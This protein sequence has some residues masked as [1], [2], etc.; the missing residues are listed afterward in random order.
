[1]RS[2]RVLAVGLVVGVIA[3]AG[4]LAAAPTAGAQTT[5][6]NGT[7]CTVSGDVDFDMGYG[8]VAAYAQ[9]FR[10]RQ[11]TFSA[12]G[13]TLANWTTGS[14]ASALDCRLTLSTLPEDETQQRNALGNLARYFTYP[15]YEGLSAWFGREPSW[16]Q[17][18]RNKI[19][20]SVAQCDVHPLVVEKLADVTQVQEVTYYFRPV[21]SSA[22]TATAALTCNSYGVWSGTGTEYDGYQN[23][24]GALSSPMK[25]GCIHYFPSGNATTFVSGSYELC[26]T[27]ISLSVAPDAIDYRPNLV[28]LWEG[29]PTTSCEGVTTPIGS[30]PDSCCTFP[31]FGPDDPVPPWSTRLNGCQGMTITSEDRSGTYYE[32]GDSVS[33]TLSA[34]DPDRPPAASAFPVTIAMNSGYPPAQTTTRSSLGDFTMTVPKDG[35][36]P[37]ME[38]TEPRL[39]DY[40]TF[41]LRCADDT[42]NLI[43]YAPDGS[44]GPRRVDPGTRS[45]LDGC[46]ADAP[47]IGI[48]PDSWVPGLVERFR[49]LFEWA[50]TPSQPVA[51]HMALWQSD[52]RNSATGQAVELVSAPYNAVRTAS[53]SATTKNTYSFA[54]QSFTL[55]QPPADLAQTLRFGIEVALIFGLGLKCLGIL[56]RALG[57][58]GL[59]PGGGDRGDD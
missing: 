17:D 55:P 9:W 39:L 56:F 47:S 31:N 42:S 37:N 6:P 28:D 43:F 52:S 29:A 34:V 20:Y 59:G 12:Q 3:G 15:L 32:V 25:L 33:F 38:D 51:Y 1:M 50:V 46:L 2:V 41:D 26:K 40:I 16:F 45:D 21:G 53:T 22:T 27:K 23:W 4:A 7:T 19:V 58:G 54:G 14:L 48:D 57:L 10:D 13:C 5:L 8:N 35:D 44:G 18:T 11:P 24:F 30:E 49:C 36:R